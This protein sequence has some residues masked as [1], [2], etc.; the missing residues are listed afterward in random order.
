MSSAAASSQDQAKTIDLDSLSL[1]QLNSYK[2][3]EESRLQ[4]VSQRYA[5]LRAASTRI[6]SARD[7]L[8]EITPT[9]EGK[10]IMVPLT[11]SL[12]APGRIKDPKT[13][14]VDLGTGFYAEKSAKDSAAFLE[15]KSRLVEANSQNVMRVV[16]TTR[17][18][19]ENVSIAMQGKMMEI[20]AR[21]EGL[22]HQAAATSSTTTTTREGS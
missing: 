9:S 18:N 8:A 7:A 15:R 16:Q 4:A 1:E 11:A 5:Q 21:Q 14:T 2:T 22:R 10:R 3:Q 6:R 17:Q 20:R 19:M 12:Y 13:F